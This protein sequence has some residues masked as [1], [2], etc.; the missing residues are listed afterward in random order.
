MDKA[1]K[2]IG[3]VMLAMVGL[4]VTLALILPDADPV[5]RPAPRRLLRPR[6]QPELEPE[7]APPPVAEAPKASTEKALK[8]LADSPIYRVG[9]R[10]KIARDGECWGIDVLLNRRATEAEM[11][12]IGNDLLNNELNRTGPVQGIVFLFAYPRGGA[13]ARLP[14]VVIWAPRGDWSRRGDAQPGRYDDFEFKVIFEDKRF[15]R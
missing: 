7:L 8:P 10:V 6:V 13:R 3:G 2:I 12:H 5:T 15:A 1:A 9:D 14:D 11:I 4:C